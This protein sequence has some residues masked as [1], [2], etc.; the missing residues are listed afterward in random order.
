MH[1]T[2]AL[3]LARHLQDDITGMIEGEGG[4]KGPKKE[5]ERAGDENGDDGVKGEGNDLC[6]VSYVTNLGNKEKAKEL[7]SAM[8]IALN[9]ML[10]HGQPPYTLSG[11]S[12]NGCKVRDLS[13]GEGSVRFLRGTQQI[14]D[15]TFAL[16]ACRFCARS[17]PLAP[18]ASAIWSKANRHKSPANPP[19]LGERRRGQVAPRPL[20]AVPPHGEQHGPARN[21]SASR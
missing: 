20:G 17:H 10:R 7:M 4:A 3:I 9:D 2:R 8:R 18:C 12:L 15:T 19:L 1:F 14:E 5:G 11:R 21:D 13:E 16:R 6:I